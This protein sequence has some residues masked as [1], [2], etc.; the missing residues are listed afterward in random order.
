MDN[1]IYDVDVARICHSAN[2]KLCETLGDF[3][4]D[5]WEQSPEWYQAKVLS[6]VR[7]HLRDPMMTPKESHESWMDHMQVDGWAYGPEF[8]RD[9][10]THPCLIP[11][12]ELTLEDQ[13]KDYLFCNI[14]E[15]LRP[16]VR[17]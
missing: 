14:I 4:H 6:C 7:A 13:R 10:K 1:P 12:E 16:L 11:F 2:R 3:S 9:K 17:R 8:D 5:R 15:A